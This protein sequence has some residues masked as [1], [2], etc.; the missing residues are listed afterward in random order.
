[1]IFME[2]IIIQLFIKILGANLES[3]IP[4]WQLYRANWKKYRDLSNCYLASLLNDQ[5]DN[6]IGK[7]VDAILKAAEESI[8]KSSAVPIKAKKPW[9]T[10]ECK[11]AV[12][13][14][15]QAL[16]RFKRYPTPHNLEIFRVTR[17]TA[18]KV[19][20]N[21]KRTTWRLFVSK[22]SNH[23]SMKQVWDM[24]HKDKGKTFNKFCCAFASC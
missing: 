10:L 13:E 17:A 14:R 1:M 9:F 24:V 23:S 12:K 4:R 3:R 6:L 18:R 21:A 22:L 11:N 5:E 20:K 7:V 16:S 15:K 8:P 2:V 19:I